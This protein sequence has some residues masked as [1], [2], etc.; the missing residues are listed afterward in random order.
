[1]M[2]AQQL[3]QCDGND[4]YNYGDD[5]YDYDYSGYGND[6]GYGSSVA[7]GQVDL[8]G[9]VTASSISGNDRSRT[10]SIIV[11]VNSGILYFFCFLD[12]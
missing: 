5:G 1:M 10:P 2:T 8:V 7:R 6:G 11:T 12:L 9:M 3:E 4:G